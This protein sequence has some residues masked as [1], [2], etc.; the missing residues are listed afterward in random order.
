MEKRTFSDA[1]LADLCEEL[2]VT[3]EAGIPV[4]E[5]F[6]LHGIYERIDRGEPADEAMDAAGAF[7]AYLVR[8]IGLGAA[9]GSLDRVLRALGAYWKSRVRRREIVRTAVSYPLL[10]ADERGRGLRR[11]GG[12]GGAV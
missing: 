11:G 5:G 8:M 3:L 4:G 10:R 1:E 12:R 9:T 6:L 7:P 2:A